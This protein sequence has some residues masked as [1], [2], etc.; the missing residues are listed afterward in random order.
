M[1]NRPL[2][3][4]TDL[5]GL[6]AT[7]ICL[8]TGTKSTAMDSL[9]NE[10]GHIAFKRL[11]PKLSFHFINWLDK[12]VQPRP[13]DRFPNAV[14]ALEALKP[15]YVIRIPGVKFN[16]L[17]RFNQSG[18]LFQATKPGEKLT[19]TIVVSNSIPKTVLQGNW[20]VVPHPNDRPHTPDAHAWI[21]FDPANFASNRNEC[22]VVVDTSKLM[23]NKV[24]KRDIVLH[25]NASQEIHS[26]PITV[27]TAPCSLVIKRIL[28]YVLVLVFAAFWATGLFLPLSATNHKF[29]F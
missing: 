21:S 16:Q 23:A 11:V 8:L 19:Q 27:E 13:K 1:F 26:L 28:Y 15:I 3:E 25:T 12:M 9:I 5:Y 4:A 2:S 7:L 20:A 10:D 24:Y 29:A 17:A 18:L 6:G 14:A 22:K